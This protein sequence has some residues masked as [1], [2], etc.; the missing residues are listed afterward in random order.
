[1]R[2]KINMVLAFLEKNGKKT[3]VKETQCGISM[4]R[5]LRATACK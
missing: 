4:Q 2:N 3:S 1:M 5:K